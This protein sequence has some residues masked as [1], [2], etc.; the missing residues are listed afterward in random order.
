M[1]NAALPDFDQEHDH[2]LASADSPQTDDGVRSAAR[3][4]C[5][6]CEARHGAPAP[7]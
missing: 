5:A 1:T 3:A 6:G 4:T 2:D 7:R